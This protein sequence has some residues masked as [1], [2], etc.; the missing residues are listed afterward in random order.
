MSIWVLEFTVT[1]T[2]DFYSQISNQF[3]FGSEL[4]FLPTW[5]KFPLNVPEITNILVTFLQMTPTTTTLLKMLIQFQ[6]GQAVFTNLLT[7]GLLEVQLL[8][9]GG[10]MKFK[11][12]A[13]TAEIVIRDKVGLTKP[14]MACNSSW[15]SLP[16]PAVIHA[17]GLVFLWNGTD[18][19]FN[20]SEF[21]MKNGKQSLLY[22]ETVSQ[23]CLYGLQTFSIFLLRILLLKHMR[24]LYHMSN[25]K[26]EI[27]FDLRI[28]TI[29]ASL[30]LDKVRALSPAANF[31]RN[32]PVATPGIAAKHCKTNQLC[33]FLLWV[34]EVLYVLLSIFNEPHNQEVISEA[35][36]LCHWI[37]SHRHLCIQCCCGK[38]QH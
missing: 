2:F 11:A 17:G 12:R 3:I 38:S 8:E 20:T 14:L 32:F 10:M 27:Y 29:N 22:V 13:K 1:L 16:A 31:L 21:W 30:Q 23:Y 9:L 28:V 26:E 37:D 5:K 35:R 33:L 7:E 18:N 25:T 19:R 24:G 15:N 34:F 4:T 6:F 36:N